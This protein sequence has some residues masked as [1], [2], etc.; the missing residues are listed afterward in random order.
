MHTYTVTEEYRPIIC[1]IS[2][3]A[4]T[5]HSTEAPHL[6]IWSHHEKDRK[7]IKQDGQP[8]ADDDD[9]ASMQQSSN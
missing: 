4:S 3:D 9:D 2:P 1:D 6:R 7:Y 8:I 5:L